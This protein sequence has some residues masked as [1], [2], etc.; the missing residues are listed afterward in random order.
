MATF[1]LMDRVKAVRAFAENRI[2]DR[3]LSITLEL[4]RRCNAKCDYCNH[5]REQ[6]QVTDWPSLTF[7]VRRW[8]AS[9]Q[10][11]WTDA[12]IDDVARYLNDSIY[13]LPARK[14]AGLVPARP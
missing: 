13:R 4:T 5:W 9:A 11:N 1:S 2:R 10:L 7:Q 8:Q 12:D 14:V 3:P 6:K